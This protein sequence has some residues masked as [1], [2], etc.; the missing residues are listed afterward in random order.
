GAT[1]TGKPE[2]YQLNK[3]GGGRSL[4]GFRKYRFYGESTFFNQFEL[5]FL[6]E[7]RTSLFNGKAGLIAFYDIGRVWQPGEI[8]STWH[9]GYGGG[10]LISPFNKFA[11]AV[12]HGR[13][14]NE[15]ATALR[16]SAGF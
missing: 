13:S 14:K 1:L 8:S 12:F 6:P 4:R 7:V 16:F 5:Q 9:S 3:I 10:I 11:V 2:F 15:R